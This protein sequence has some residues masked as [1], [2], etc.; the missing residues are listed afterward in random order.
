[1][2]SLPPPPPGE[3]IVLPRVEPVL[4]SDRGGVHGG[5][6]ELGRPLTSAASELEL[7]SLRPYRQG[8]PASR[9]HWPTVARTGALVERRLVADA[10][11]RPLVVLDT[12]GPPS[13]GSIDM[14][15]RAAA[16]LVVHLARG[17]GCSLLLPGDRRPVDVDED[18]HAWPALHVRLALLEADERPPSAARLQRSGPIFWV[19]ARAPGRL[20]AG[21]ARAA[22]SGRYLVIPDEGARGTPVFSVAGCSGFRLGR[23]GRRRA[24]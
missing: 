7:D 6:G 23:A 21:L 1:V 24:A 3:V 4:V 17:G 5:L 15:V 12:R 8:A 14:A 16:S 22:A 10:D 11:A 19:A 9:I 2:R 18:L 20:P 13:P